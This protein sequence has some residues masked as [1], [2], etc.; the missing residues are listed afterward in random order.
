MTTKDIRLSPDPDMA[1]SYAAMQRAGKAAEDLA[2]RTNTAIITM[3]DGKVVR[4]TADEIIK[5]REA[6][7][8]KAQVDQE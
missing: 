8:Q 5:R 2:I 3:I 1:G 6:E 7:S 4:L